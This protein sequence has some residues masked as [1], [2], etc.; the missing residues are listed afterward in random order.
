MNILFKAIR[1]IVF[2]KDSVFRKLKPASKRGGQNDESYYPWIMHSKRRCRGME[3]IKTALGH[4]D[5]EQNL[6]L[7]NDD[8]LKGVGSN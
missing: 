2:P 1:A 3:M 5:V 8:L 7:R 6:P 4:T